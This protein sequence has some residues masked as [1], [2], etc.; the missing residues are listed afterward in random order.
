M[1]LVL[2]VSHTEESM[3]QSVFSRLKLLPQSQ[4]KDV[5]RYPPDGN[6]DDREE[7]GFLMIG[8][9]ASDRTTVTHQQYVDQHRMH[10]PPDYAQTQMEQPPGYQGAMTTGVVGMNMQLSPLDMF[11]NNN[12]MLP[13]ADIPFQ[14]APHL[15]LL[16]RLDS[17]DNRLG[18]Q[19]STL[20][21][22]KYD[23]DFSYELKYLQEFG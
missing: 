16:Q 13:L 17:L 4:T 10:S 9:T 23:Y 15:S 18:L 6:H 3:L 22:S 11:S 19:T 20:D 7:D 8:E 2:D 14:L 21:L 1:Y 5:T 12:H